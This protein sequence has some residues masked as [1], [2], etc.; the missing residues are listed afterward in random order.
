MS[1]ARTWTPLWGHSLSSWKEVFAE[2]P[3]MTWTPT[4]SF[5]ELGNHHQLTCFLYWR[6]VYIVSMWLV[7]LLCSSSFPLLFWVV[8]ASMSSVGPLSSH[9]LTTTTPVA[10]GSFGVTPYS[11]IIVF[12]SASAGYANGTWNAL[13]ACL[14]WS[15]SYQIE[16]YYIIQMSREFNSS[17]LR[18]NWFQ[19]CSH[20]MDFWILETF[21]ICLNRP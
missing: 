10:S 6:S 21:G 5:S 3:S 11:P 13:V 2:R 17:T 18:E 8:V 19:H 14:P 12:P 9:K 4:R 20:L 16:R 15:W 1:L 7:V